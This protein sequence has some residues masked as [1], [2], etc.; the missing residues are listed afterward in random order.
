MI[1]SGVDN[2]HPLPL[3]C[4]II[5]YHSYLLHISETRL[6]YPSTSHTVLAASQRSEANDVPRPSFPTKG[7]VLPPCQYTS[8]YGTM[9]EIGLSR[10]SQDRYFRR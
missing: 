6:T 4:R 8:L 9:E 1:K 2:R 10:K 3:T 7:S 5:E